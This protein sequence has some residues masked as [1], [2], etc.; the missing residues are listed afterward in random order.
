MS[1]RRNQRS[2]SAEAYRG[3]YKL[4]IWLKLRAEQL[5]RQPL[6]ERCIKRDK[7]VPATVVNHRKPHKGDWKLFIDPE[8]HQSLCKPCH[9]GPVQSAERGGRTVEIGV[10][11]WPI[12]PKQVARN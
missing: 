4:A 5:A 6:C 3:W 12:E 9:D 10:D 2:S 1:E 7:V 11:G 8:N